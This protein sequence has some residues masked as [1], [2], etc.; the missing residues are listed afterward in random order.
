MSA[1]TSSNKA[2]IEVRVLM[3]W[4]ARWPDGEANRDAHV[5]S[6]LGQGISFPVIDGSGALRLSCRAWAEAA[7][8]MEAARKA[9]RK[10]RPDEAI[11]P[12]GRL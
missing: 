4:G 9:E 6:R 8:T 3:R 12:L 2:V 5:Q 11:E 7:P 10:R 1:A